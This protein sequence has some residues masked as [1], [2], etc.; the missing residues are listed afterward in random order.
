M[1]VQ[2]TIEQI[3]RKSASSERSGLTSNKRRS[4]KKTENFLIS[5]ETHFPAT[6]SRA[7]CHL[8]FPVQRRLKKRAVEQNSELR[9]FLSFSFSVEMFLVSQYQNIN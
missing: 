7:N 6:C 2:F 5:I 3:P 9:V 1:D 4:S 8:R